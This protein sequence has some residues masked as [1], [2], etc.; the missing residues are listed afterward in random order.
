M[1]IH[2]VVDQP[3]R[4]AAAWLRRGIG[5]LLGTLLILVGLAAVPLSLFAAFLGRASSTK[6]AAFGTG[7]VVLVLT[8]AAAVTILVPLAG[9]RLLRGRRNLVLFLRRFGY[10]DATV[11]ITFAVAQTIGRSWR[12]VTL[13]DAA[14][15]PVGVSTPVKRAFG[16]GRVGTAF[17]AK[18]WRAILGAAIRLMTAAVAGML[19]VFG[20]IVLHHRSLATLATNALDTKHA[21]QWDAPGVLRVLFVVTVVAAAVGVGVSVL[22]LPALAFLNVSLFLSISARALRDAEQ[23]KVG[24]IRSA[25]GGEQMAQALR[26]Q[27]RKIFSPRL[28]V[29]TV[30]S[31]V[32]QAA[33]RSL[34]SDAVVVLIDVSEPTENLLWEIEE[35]AADPTVRFVLVGSLDRLRQMADVN[36][37]P[38]PGSLAGRLAALLDGREVLAYTADRRS[39]KRFARTLRA[40][41]EAAAAAD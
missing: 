1:P 36:A 33:V 41:L 5:R 38:A 17:L 13:D 24:T 26:R 29:L 7:T 14:I 11:A 40:S 32:W 23:A 35:V 4:R 18:T 2:I 27:A 8:V 21:T 30:A 19:V 6:S 15:V 39:M 3:P 31:E 12:L 28:V 20:F 37:A 10:S 16:A 9:I 34:A 22:V 25:K